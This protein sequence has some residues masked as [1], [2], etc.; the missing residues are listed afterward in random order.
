MTATY[1][2]VTVSGAD[3]DVY[4]P[5]ADADAYLAAEFSDAATR[6]RDATLTD[7]DAKARALVSATRLIDRQRWAGTKTD[8]D[9]ALAWPRTGTGLTDVE[10][11]VIPLDIINASILIAADINNGVNVTG[12]SS[13]DDRV[14]SQSAGSVSISYF[15]D[16][17]GGTRFPTAIQELLGRFMAGGAGAY[18]GV[19]V[20]GV[21]GESAFGTSYGLNGPI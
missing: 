20:S 12:S 4:A 10:D 5:V 13:T 17:D 7:A 1:N 18:G 15:R 3:Y 8:T 21:D 6:W 19:L 11:D 16:L 9:Q 2:T 14:R